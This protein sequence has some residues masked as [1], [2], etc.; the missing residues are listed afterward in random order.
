MLFF[1]YSG[2]ARVLFWGVS[3]WAF[4]AFGAHIYDQS[5]A[6]RL[7]RLVN[8]SGLDI[9][10]AWEVR[11]LRLLGAQELAFPGLRYVMLC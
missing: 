3:L 11:V 5:V 6:F 10:Q 4:T 2:G 7:S 1:F 9:Y 8:L